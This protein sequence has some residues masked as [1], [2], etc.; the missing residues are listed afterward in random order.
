MRS[1]YAMAVGTALVSCLLAACGGGGGGEPDKAPQGALS[2]AFSSPV[3]T[4]SN[5]SHF[6]AVWRPQESGSAASQSALTIIDTDTQRVVRTYDTYIWRASSRVQKS[7][8]SPVYGSLGIGNVYMI[9]NGQVLQL[10][11]SGD[12]LGTA[13]RISS[14]TQA[15]YLGSS[16]FHVNKDGRHDWLR[17]ITAG[18]SGDC[19]NRTDARAFLVASDMSETEVGPE[20]GPHSGMTVLSTLPDAQG[21]ATGILVLDTTTG[22][23]SVYATD[24][25]S[26]RYSVADKVVTPSDS[27]DMIAAA[28]DADQKAYFRAANKLY[29]LDWQGGKVVLGAPLIQLDEPIFG[30]NYTWDNAFLYFVSSGGIYQAASDRTIRLLGQLDSQLG[31]AS[32]LVNA[33]NSIFVTQRTGNALDYSLSATSSITSLSKATGAARTWLTGSQDILN[34]VGASGDE[35]VLL[36]Y[37]FDSVRYKTHILALNQTDGSTRTLGSDVMLA[38][39][40]PSLANPESVAVHPMLLWAE[41]NSALP[42]TSQPARNLNAYSPGQGSPV[43]MGTLP[44]DDPALQQVYLVSWPMVKPI[45]ATSNVDGGQTRFWSVQA[46]LAQ[47]LSP[48]LAL[49]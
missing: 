34:A 11:L 32:G 26:R 24:M 19:S 18:P 45:I 20:V 36:K 39:I 22:D 35:L 9:L 40:L 25:K 43:I 42:Y 38:G 31:S 8:G 6:S 44:A 1:R 14:I 4:S 15:C 47:S 49:P 37:E 41:N 10:D 12:T 33:G 23:L 7:P 46:D 17:V 16:T 28:P 21:D 2:T 48:I 30:L 3:N 5:V 13:R 29:L 27:F